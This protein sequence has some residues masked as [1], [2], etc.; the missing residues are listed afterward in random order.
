MEYW[1]LVVTD[2]GK[3]VNAIYGLINDT[4]ENIIGRDGGMLN[5][6]G[7]WLSQQDLQRFK[8]RFGSSVVEY[9]YNCFIKNNILLSQ[10]DT[11]LL[12]AY[13]NFFVRKF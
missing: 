2:T 4:L 9:Q 13:P 12:K 11:S 7:S 1:T 3:Q 5:F 10:T 8:K 6:G